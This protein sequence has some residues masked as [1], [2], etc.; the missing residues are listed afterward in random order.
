M[1][2][3]GGGRRA[4]KSGP[5]EQQGVAGEQCQLKE[6]GSARMLDD[7]CRQKVTQAWWPHWQCWGWGGGVLEIFRLTEALTLKAP[8][9]V[10]TDGV[11]RV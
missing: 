3:A 4:N 6:L 10:G 9:H 7:R 8:G 2:S 5:Q 1:G 11:S